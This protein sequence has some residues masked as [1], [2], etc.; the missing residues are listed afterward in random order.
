[1]TLD[2]RL[3][4]LKQRGDRGGGVIAY[5]VGHIHRKGE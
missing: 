5:L 1:M 4:G 2:A 3:K